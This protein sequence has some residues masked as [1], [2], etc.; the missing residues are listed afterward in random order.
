MLYAVIIKDPVMKLSAKISYIESTW[1][2]HFDDIFIFWT[3][4]YIKIVKKRKYKFLT[5]VH[6]SKRTTIRAEYNNSH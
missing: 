1:M 6:F 3:Q 5:T 4:N 2:M